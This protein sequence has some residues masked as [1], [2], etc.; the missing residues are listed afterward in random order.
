MNRAKQLPDSYVKNVD[1]NNYKLLQLANLLYVDLNADLKKI[2]QSRDLY[3]ATGKTLDY[4]GAMVGEKRNGASDEQF[5]T[6]I[7]NRIGRNVANSDC[8]S[9]ITIVAN[10]LDI[11]PETIRTVEGENSV[12]VVGLTV[13]TI[14]KSGYTS[15]ELIEMME[16]LL[17]IGVS[18]AGSEITGSLLIFDILNFFG[19]DAVFSEY[20]RL[21]TA[22]Y[23]G[24]VEYAKG[25]DVGLSGYGEVPETFKS[26]YPNYQTSG[27]YTGGTL[28]VLT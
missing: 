3:N 14:E 24:Q 27:T 19:D 6:K 26:V 18:M 22:W 4:Y 16:N 25:N 2:N 10:M 23:L 1:S 9:F 7:L 28:S 5:R 11:K 20:P 15:E 8:N 17:P 12:E 13:E 21:Y